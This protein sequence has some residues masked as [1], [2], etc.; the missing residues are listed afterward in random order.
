MDLFDYMRE[1]NN[2]KRGSPCGQASS[3]DLGRSG[4]AAAYY[5]KGQAAYIVPSK[6]IS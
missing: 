5:R 6:Q 1:Q 4:G 2:G 3:H